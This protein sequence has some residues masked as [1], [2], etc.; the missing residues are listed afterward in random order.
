MSGAWGCG[1]VRIPVEVQ[2]RSE[3]PVRPRPGTWSRW[4]AR[5]QSS[6]RGSSRAY[7][8]VRGRTKSAQPPGA[9]M[10]GYICMHLKNAGKLA[11]KR[12]GCRLRQPRVDQIG[13][14]ALCGELSIPHKVEAPERPRGR[15]PLHLKCMRQPI[16]PRKLRPCGGTRLAGAISLTSCPSAVSA[17]QTFIAWIELAVSEGMREVGDRRD[18]HA[19][20]PRRCS[21]PRP[22][23]TISPT[24]RT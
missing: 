10:T 6:A 11:M 7:A 18:P 19:G 21:S 13:F 4:S 8:C 12:K 2:R 23:H 22:R 24:E 16:V 14:E 3:R 9:E 5:G 20:C 1:Q 17:S 15:P